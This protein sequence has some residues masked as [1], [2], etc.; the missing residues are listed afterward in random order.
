MRIFIALVVSLFVG[1]TV[2]VQAQ[3]EVLPLWAD[4]APGFEARKDIPERAKDWWVRDIHNPS[5]TLFSPS[6]VR[7]ETTDTA[8]IV[9]PGGGHKDLVFN[10]EG[11][12]AA[13]FLAENGITAFALKY[14]L[15]RQPG[16]D[17]DIE[18]H[19][20]E[21]L[22]RA[23]RYVRANAALYNLN[24]DRIGVMGFSA[25]GELVNLVTYGETAGDDAS[26]DRVER[27]SARPDFQI[28]I[29][30]G[31]IGLPDHLKQ[32]PPPAFF[33]SAFDDT[34][35]ELTISRHLDMYRT[36]GVAAEVHIFA[37]GGH[38]FNMG[39]RSKLETISDWPERLKDW[40]ED[41]GYLGQP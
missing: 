38:A 20:A 36:A 9:V 26:S 5:L 31:P 14:R 29:Y 11:A 24:P 41:S 28:Q 21:D 30:P 10:S 22:R 15:A 34:G 1:C 23:V 12:K 17:Y 35:P 7:Q 18:T 25:G 13:K 19:A 2:S 6:E 3:D 4:G 8:I 37:Q 27:V 33:L 39:D 16:S 32:P 40:L